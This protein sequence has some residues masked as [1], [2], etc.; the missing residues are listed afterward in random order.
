MY[1]V[2]ASILVLLGIF[3]FLNQPEKYVSG[4]GEQLAIILPDNSKVILNANS[5]LSFNKN[6]WNENRN[7][8][9]NGEAYFKV[10][11]GSDFVVETKEGKV[12]VLGTQFNVKTDTDF[13]EVICYEGK[14]KAETNTL[15]TILIK[16]DAFRKMKGSLPEK[17]MISAVE[18]S[19]K[20]GESS[21]KSVPL[22]YVIK[23]LKTDLLDNILKKSFYNLNF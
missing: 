2:A 15:N 4:I 16:G 7:L 21:F 12:T 6:N 14:V 19:W 9:L 3:Y 8:N 23:A 11:K 20:K 22:E 1:S 18:P 17:W 13:F 5:T 10:E